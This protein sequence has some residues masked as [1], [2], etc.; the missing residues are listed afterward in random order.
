MSLALTR[1]VYATPASIDPPAVE[2][3]P[4]VFFRDLT[5][6]GNQVFVIFAE[7]VIVFDAGAVVEA[8]N[9]LRI[10][11]EHTDKPIRYVINSHFHP[12]H[13][14]GAAVFAAEGAEVVAAAA[15]R[16]DFDVWVPTDFAR[17]A[18]ANPADYAGLSYAPPTR[19]IEASWTIDDGYQR[20][21]IL[22]FGHGHT[23]GDL[24]GWMPR[25][26]ILF[27][28]DLSTNGQHNLANANL[29]GWIHV[30]ERLRA[31]NPRLVV[32]GHKALTGPDN[33]RRSY[34]YLTELRRQVRDMVELNMSYEQILATIDIPMYEEWSGVP[35]RDEPVHV[36]KAFTEAG[37]VRTR[38]FISRRRALLLTA[39]GI[40]VLLAL[41]LSRRRESAEVPEIES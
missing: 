1:G 30:L 16:H 32:P 28:Q 5:P 14:A 7:F 39:L 37:G 31:L 20:L 27:S 24:V 25:R 22:H 18:A 34:R 36:L 12:D 21:E 19:W 33:L 11:R 9:L 3:A 23:A 13:S 29:S 26:H 2:L 15:G 17:K 35:V 4:G 38:P 41:Y 40:V 8:R 6:F 10:I